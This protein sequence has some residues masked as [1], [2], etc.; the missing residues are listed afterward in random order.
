M[1]RYIKD[2]TIKFANQIVIRKNNMQII[3]PKE[4]QIL[5]DG[6]TEY[7]VE[8]Y[9]PTLNDIKR[10]K[11][12]ELMIHDSSFEVNEFMVNGTGM[13]L[14]KA[15]RAGLMLRFQAEK[16][17][18]REDTTLWYDGLPFPLKVDDALQMLYTVEIYASACYDNTQY[19]IGII[20][21]FTTEEEVEN[22][23]YRTGYPEKL[24]F[25]F[26]VI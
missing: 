18:G 7:V 9:V 14:D 11:K 20:D 8:P 17:S 2:K 6:W 1:K 26:N 23:D 10:N 25:D 22:Y 15:T 24:N 19:H 21:S 12:E 16:N 4:E 3:N 5:E 13:W